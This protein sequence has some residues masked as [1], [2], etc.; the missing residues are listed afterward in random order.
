[1][2]QIEQLFAFVAVKQD[3]ESLIIVKPGDG[4]RDMP[5]VFSDPSHLELCRSFAEEEAKK[6]DFSLKLIRFNNRAELLIKD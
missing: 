2:K 3:G 5:L 6:S 4:A 1:M